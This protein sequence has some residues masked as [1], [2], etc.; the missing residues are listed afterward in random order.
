MQS[1]G[2]GCKAE[3]LTHTDLRGAGL[4]SVVAT[5]TWMRGSGQ[6]PLRIRSGVTL[7]GTMTWMGGLTAVV[8]GEVDRNPDEVGVSGLA[9]VGKCSGLLT[10]VGTM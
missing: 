2:M 8:T 3:R 5:G 9:S 4:S 1:G 6:S 10:P 7:G